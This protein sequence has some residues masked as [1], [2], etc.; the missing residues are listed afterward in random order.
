MACEEQENRT[1]LWVLLDVSNCMRGATIES[2][3][4][5]LQQYVLSQLN[6][7]GMNISLITF[8][9]TACLITETPSAINDFVLPEE[10]SIGGLCNLSDALSLCDNMVAPDDKIL[11]LTKGYTTDSYGNQKNTMDNDCHVVM[12][13]S[14]SNRIPVTLI[15]YFSGKLK[16]Y[17]MKEESLKELSINLNCSKQVKKRR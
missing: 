10:F 7:S 12:L 13:D 5:V 4:N 9:N 3:R 16:V 1:T 11:L 2:A 8:G 17:N 14:S 15:S 6:N